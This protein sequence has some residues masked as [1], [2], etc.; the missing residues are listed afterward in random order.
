MYA[1]AIWRPLYVPFLCMY[2]VA[3]W[4]LLYVPFVCMYAVA[5]WWLLYVPFVLCCDVRAR[6]ATFC[7]L[8]PYTD[9]ILDVNTS[10]KLP[11]LLG[12]KAGCYS[13]NNNTS[14]PKINIFM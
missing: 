13:D 11:L 6:L 8:A 5:I 9:E 2:A 14:K 3:I 4:R 7:W 10:T 12:P 1:V